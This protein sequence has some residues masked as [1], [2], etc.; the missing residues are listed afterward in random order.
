M[1]LGVDT[2]LCVPAHG[3]DGMGVRRRRW[4]VLLASG[5]I[6]EMGVVALW[7]FGGNNDVRRPVGGR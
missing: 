3:R 6:A 4:N 5:V 1:Y 2:Y 7:Y